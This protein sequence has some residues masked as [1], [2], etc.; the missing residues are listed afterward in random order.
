MI[1]FEKNTP[2]SSVWSKKLEI[3]PKI[4]ENSLNCILFRLVDSPVSEVETEINRNHDKIEDIENKDIGQFLHHQLRCDA[5]GVSEQNHAEKKQTFSL[6]CTGGK[7]FPYGHGPGDS[8]ADHHQ[9]LEKFRHRKP[10]L[11]NVP[12]LIVIISSAAPKGKYMLLHEI[13]YDNYL[14]TVILICGMLQTIK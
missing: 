14:F 3:R 9:R 6:R 10:L 7:G 5:A 13:R 11:I 2:N 4:W 8:K 1:F 12:I